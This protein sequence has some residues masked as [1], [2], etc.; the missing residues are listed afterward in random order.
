MEK[1]TESEKVESIIWKYVGEE[2]VK[3]IKNLGSFVERASKEN[4]TPAEIA[5]LANVAKAQ[6]E[7]FERIVV[8]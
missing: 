8:V 3:L 5:A 1:M 6:I 7:L 4:A 2:R